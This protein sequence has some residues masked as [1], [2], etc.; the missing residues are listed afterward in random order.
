MRL[1]LHRP[2]LLQLVDPA[3]I[4]AGGVKEQIPVDQVELL[5]LAAPDEPEAALWVD[6]IH[7]AAGARRTLRA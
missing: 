7:D 5:G 1:E 4:E 3:V 2:A 6:A